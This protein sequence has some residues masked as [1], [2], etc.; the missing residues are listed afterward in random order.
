[1]ETEKLHATYII[2]VKFRRNPPQATLETYN[3]N[4]PTFDDVQQEEFLALLRN[5][6]ITFDRTGTTTAPGWINYLHTMLRGTSLR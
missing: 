6:K 3:K 4:T 1:M 2:K 5:F